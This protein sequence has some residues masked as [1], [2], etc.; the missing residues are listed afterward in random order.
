MAKVGLVLLL[1]S[2]TS[3][4]PNV[5]TVEFQSNELDSPIQNVLFC[6][7]DNEV[8]LGLTKKRSVYRSENK[9]FSWRPLQTILQRE[10]TAQAEAG[11]NLGQVTTIKQSPVDP[12]L[13]V[14]IGSK[15]INWFSDDCGKS[16]WALNSGKPIYDFMFHPLE[17]DWGLAASWTACSELSKE[18]CELYKELYVTKNL[19]DWTLVA[20]YVVQFSWAQDTL[21][22]FLQKRIPN[23]RIYVTYIPGASGNQS[24]KGWTHR[25][26]MVKSDDYFQSTTTL[27]PRGNKFIIS[28]RYILVAQVIEDDSSE[29]QL[30]TSNERNLELFTKAEL[31]IKHLAEHSYTLLDTSEESIFLFINHIGA[32]APYGNVYIS[33][34]SGRRFALSLLRT[35]QG[36]DGT[37]D[38]DK[39]YG[40]E[41]IYIA[42]VYDKD[43]VLESSQTSNQARGKPNKAS[44][45][46]PD[47]QPSKRTQIT[48][49]KGSIWHNLPA[50]A[51]DSAGKKVVCE[52]EECY[53]HLHS[54]AARQYSPVYSTSSAVGLILG[55]GNVGKYLSLREDEINTY[56]SRDGG[57]TWSEVMKGSHIYE[58]GD[59][60]A[61]IIMADNREA[62]DTIYYSWNEGLRWEPLKIT[63]NPI[64]IENIIIS[65]G[66]IAQTF[67]VLGTKGGKG[68][69]VALDFSSLHE[70]QCQGV[71]YPDSDKSDY[72]LWTP[73]DGRAGSKCLM[74]RTVSYIRRKQEAECY[75][76]IEFERPYLKEACTC[77]EDDYECDI[78]FYREGSSPCRPVPNAEPSEKCL[79]GEDYYEVPTGYRRVAGNTCEGGVSFKYDPPRFPCSTG[80]FGI[81]MW[82]LLFLVCT[83]I[84]G[85]VSWIKADEF[86]PYI[87]E[88]VSEVIQ[89]YREPAYS[90]GFES[91]PDTVDEDMIIREPVEMR[92][93]GDDRRDEEFN[94]R[95]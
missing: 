39:I 9:G 21:D 47:S 28:S 23:D 88:K 58:L 82:T 50:P 13:V 26:N 55:T 22:P 71:E 72:E 4:A 90:R 77:T 48:F 79:P 33:D 32:K 24:V 16:I 19:K 89:K 44:K 68:V 49:D 86:F 8:M 56:M 3:A 37:C 25:I 87:K 41:G 59:H 80:A 36:N 15:G 53:L 42:N 31:P 92:R 6:G 85:Y 34:A 40:L 62:T 93:S 74:G 63:P 29:V 45:S 18:P 30:L 94:P 11:Q 66:A 38:F 67:L 20:T 54:L 52:D 57:L 65:P 43:T 70:P 7:A 78:G 61:L 95:D 76:G 83:G 73:N 84:L 1:V 46:S 2:L 69:T 91:A 14:M 64:E 12:R 17:R 81:S 35:P 5:D 27:V 51:T 75:N 60:G 10:G